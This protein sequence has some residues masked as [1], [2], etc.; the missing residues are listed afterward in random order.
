MFYTILD[1]LIL[2]QSLK[3]KPSKYSNYELKLHNY[4]YNKTQID[5]SYIINVKIEDEHFIFF[6]INKYSYFQAKDYLNSIRNDIKNRKVLIIRIDKILINFVF[7]LFADLCIDDVK[8]EINHMKGKYEILIYFLKDLNTYHIA[9]GKKGCYIKA[10]NV[11]FNNYIDFINCK[12][13]LTIRCRA[14]D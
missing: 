12:T 4:F 14:T 5:P 6:F 9:V 1:D 7:N 13:P 2:Y 11:L 10:V 3:I 8:I